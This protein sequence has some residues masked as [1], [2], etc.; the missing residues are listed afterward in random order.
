M[1]IRIMMGAAPQMSAVRFYGSGSRGGGG[2]GQKGGGKGMDSYGGKGMDMYGGK[3]MDPYGGKGMDYGGKGMDP[4]G[5]K[6]MDPYGGKGMDPYGGKGM[7]P[8]GG[9]GMDPYGGKG[10]D[11]YGGKGMDPYG[12]KGG[13]GS[14]GAPSG[15]KG[16]DPYG[17]KGMDPYGG[18]GMDPYGGKGM[19]PYGGKGM[20]PYGGKGGKGMDPYGGKGMDP[21]GGK[22]MD[23]YGGKGM[24]PYGGKGSRGMGMDM[25]PYSGK[26]S[27]GGDPYGA[28]GGMAMAGGAAAAGGMAAYGGGGP[29]PPVKAD[30][31][32]PAGQVPEIGMFD[33]SD[34]M[35][36][37]FGFL[38]GQKLRVTNPQNPKEMF[39]MV[40]VGAALDPAVGSPTMWFHI[41][42]EPGAGTFQPEMLEAYR[43][44]MEVVGK[45]KL[46]PLTAAEQEELKQ[47]VKLQR[48][49]DL[50]DLNLECFNSWRL[51]K[52]LRKKWQPAEAPEKAPWP[53]CD[54]GY[55]MDTGNPSMPPVFAK[56]DRRPETVGVFTVQDGVK[57]Q[58]GMTLAVT[59]KKEKE[60]EEEIKDYVVIGVRPIPGVKFVLW[61]H[62]EDEA[63][64]RPLTVKQLSTATVKNVP[65]VAVEEKNGKDFKES[66]EEVDADQLAHFNKFIMRAERAVVRRV[67]TKKS[68]KAAASPSKEEDSEASAN[69]TP[70][71]DE[72]TKDSAQSTKE[73]K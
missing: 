71:K 59:V 68:K 12:G 44:Y 55:Q 58:Q 2:K 60:Q 73:K 29:S 65:P 8:Y 41:A 36:R 27:K 16:M 46:N 54:F 61:A 25:D 37:S 39:E 49:M 62:A 26:G 24:D 21:Y 35:C 19:D 11:P 6:G 30:F 28:K 18:K 42:G 15:G 38:H 5:G 4:Y 56:F 32:Y 43:E 31:A 48:R 63:G 20:D 9:K 33:I 45:V 67:K 34:E 23:P 72:A 66:E 70:D 17:G 1:A 7:D 40:V 69:Q 14:R 10:M 52:S 64:A 22:G 53:T 3:G 51:T 13:Y 47:H 50:N 57:L